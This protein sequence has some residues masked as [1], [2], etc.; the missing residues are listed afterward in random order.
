MTVD[1]ELSSGSATEQL[2]WIRLANL[3]TLTFHGL[4]SDRDASRGEP[5]QPSNAQDLPHS[6]RAL[7]YG[8]HA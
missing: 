3:T 4:G 5:D 8:D 2:L 7:L 6:H 1:D